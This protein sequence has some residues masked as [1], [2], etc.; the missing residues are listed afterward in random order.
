MYS[1][2]QLHN[3]RIT[4]PTETCTSEPRRTVK[5]GEGRAILADRGQAK[6][7]KIRTQC[8]HQ[9]RNGM[10]PSKISVA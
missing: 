7:K 2:N 10:R 9:Y 5:Y 3:T 6:M 4:N 1:I 8:R